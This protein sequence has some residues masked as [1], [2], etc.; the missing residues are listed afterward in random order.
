M[1]REN[2]TPTKHASTDNNVETETKENL[3]AITEPTM[4]ANGQYSLF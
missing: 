3:S 1:E 4:D 2:T